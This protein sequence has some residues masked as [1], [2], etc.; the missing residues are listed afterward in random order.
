MSANVPN[1]ENEFDEFDDGQT[2]ADTGAT[3]VSPPPAMPKVRQRS[4]LCPSAWI[5]LF[6]APLPG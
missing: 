6:L 2:A 3:R 4:Y 1:I 5:G